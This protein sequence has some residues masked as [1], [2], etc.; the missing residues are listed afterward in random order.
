M[1][2]P[3]HAMSTIEER[4]MAALATGQRQAAL[5]EVVS[6]FGPEVLG[7][8]AAVHHDADVAAEVFAETCEDLV[9]TFDQFRGDCSFRTWL[10]A[11]AKTASR[12][13]FEVANRRVRVN[14]SDAPEFAAAC[15]TTTAKF[16]QTAWKDR[17]QALRGALSPDDRALL[18]LRVDRDLPWNDI[19]RVLAVDG[20]APSTAALRKRFERI[21]VT[22]RA[23]AKGQGW[24][25]P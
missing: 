9:R 5:T 21:K 17:L 23:H 6:G 22:L 16:L 13:H 20:E 14:L 11:L 12:R 8:L 15:R 24:F 2:S 3:P 18:V 7:F 25:D 19:A 10:F 1:S 4:A